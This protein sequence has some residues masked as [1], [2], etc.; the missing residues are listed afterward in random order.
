MASI[1][2]IRL[3][4]GARLDTIAGLEVFDY[5][6]YSLQPPAA[7]VGWPDVEFDFVLGRGADRLSIPVRVFVA[8]ASDHSSNTELEAYISPSGAKSV[9]AA[10]EADGSLGGAAHSSRVA[11]ASGVGIF[12][13]AGIDFLGVEF[14]IDVI[15]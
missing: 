13:I 7:V 6:P 11:R 3:G 1:N 15:N 10:V 4:L 12:N 14:T 5:V 9:K 8:S 2:A